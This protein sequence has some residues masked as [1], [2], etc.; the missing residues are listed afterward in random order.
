MVNVNKTKW[1]NDTRLLADLSSTELFELKKEYEIEIAKIR[2]ELRERLTN[3]DEVFL[4]ENR[5]ILKERPVVSHVKEKPVVPHVKEKPVVPHVKEKPVV[6]HVKEKPVVPHVKEKPVVS[7]VK[8]KPVVP[9]VKERPVVSHV[10]EKPVVP[11]IKAKLK[12]SDWQEELNVSNVPWWLKDYR[13][14]RKENMRFL[15]DDK[16]KA[17]IEATKTIELDV[18]KERE[19]GSRLIKFKIDGKL[20][21][22]LDVDLKTHTDER[23]AILGKWDVTW[24]RKTEVKLWWM[25]WNNI[26]MWKNGKLKTYI[27][28]ERDNEWLHLWDEVDLKNLLS[29]LWERAGLSD[30]WDQIAMLM[31]L[32]GMEWRYRWKMI[33]GDSSPKLVCG[34]EDCVLCHDKDKDNYAGLFLFG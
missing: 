20:Y 26:D 10:K 11:H 25:R 27:K 28:R 1:L 8:E 2:K 6:P 13:E 15:S 31:Y 18:E 12:T 29:K 19:D 9:H 17:I 22:I 5:R 16:K 32:T 34:D 30:K 14:A 4:G 33:N 3:S 7:H 21:R 23:Y 24:R